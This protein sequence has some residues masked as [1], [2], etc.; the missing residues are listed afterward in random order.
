[1]GEF[2]FKAPKKEELQSEVQPFPPGVVAA[3]VIAAIV[4]IVPALTGGGTPEPVPTA[5]TKITTAEKSGPDRIVLSFLRAL[6]SG[7]VQGAYT[8]LSPEKREQ[9]S[10]DQFKVE[11]EAFL[12]DDSQAFR[13]MRA[14]ITS[15]DIQSTTAEI[16]VGQSSE[17]TS[18]KA[19]LR[20]VDGVWYLDS[21]SGGPLTL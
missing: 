14:Q 17:E 4:L 7:S 5:T 16:T 10:L 2:E 1:M 20:R 13:L 6:G 11:A 8:F 21:L 12:S 9:L 15:E 19:T 18:W 3:C